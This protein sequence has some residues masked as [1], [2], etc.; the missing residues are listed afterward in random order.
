MSY[1]QASRSEI[2]ARI[3]PGRVPSDAGDGRGGLN[4]RYLAWEAPQQAARRPLEQRGHNPMTLEGWSA[5]GMTDRANR[6]LAE[7]EQGRWELPTMPN[8]RSD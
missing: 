4:A 1:M 2:Q 5:D 8:R 7:L 3:T 6:Y